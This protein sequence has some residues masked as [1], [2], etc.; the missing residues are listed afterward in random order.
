MRSAIKSELDSQDECPVDSGLAHIATPDI[1][2]D[3]FAGYSGSSSFCP[4]PAVR[5]H[6]AADIIVSNGIDETKDGAKG[7]RVSRWDEDEHK[8]FIEALRLYGNQWSRVQE[9]VGTRSSMQ[10]R[11]HAQ[12][13][14]KTVTARAI[15]KIKKEGKAS[16]TMFIVTREYRNTA[17]LG[18]KKPHEIYLDPDVKINRPSYYK[19]RDRGLKTTSEPMSWQ[20]PDLPDLAGRREHPEGEDWMQYDPYLEFIDEERLAGSSSKY[21]AADNNRETAGHLNGE[22]AV[23]EEAVETNGFVTSVRYE[24]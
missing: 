7:F 12:K 21:N 15:K 2:V 5:S 4:V 20:G 8:R 24:E 14:F 22:V 13:Y 17:C 11:S 1:E 18:L 23:L 9:H 6:A 19:K 10:I 3:T 16:R